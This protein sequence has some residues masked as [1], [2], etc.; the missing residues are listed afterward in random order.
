MAVNRGSGVSLWRQ[1]QLELEDNIAQQRLT[2]GEKCPTEQMLALRFGVN[3]HTVRRA[4]AAMEEKGLL[5]V[6]QGRGTFV[7]ERVVK[8]PV[9]KRTRFSATIR[10]Q[11]KVPAGTLVHSEIIG[12]DRDTAQALDIPYGTSVILLRTLN[13]VDDRPLGLVDHFF[14]QERCAGLAE[15]FRQTGSI[16]GALARIGIVDY[17]RKTTRVMARMPDR[18]EAQTLRQPVNRPLLITESI[19]VD[20]AGVPLE[21]GVARFSADRMQLLIEP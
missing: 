17:L 18:F 6:E 16:T 3:R 19:N 5:R 13:E 20:T 15:A 4:I 1:I 14:P 11:N 21:Y 7:C 9:S 8:Y 2:P 10:A 12:A